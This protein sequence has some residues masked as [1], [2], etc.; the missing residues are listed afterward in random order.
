MDVCERVAATIREYGLLRRGQKVVAAV[1]GGADS[2]CLLDC[3]HRLGFP[4]VVAHLNHRLREGSEAD[5]EYTLRIAQQYGLPV[6][7]ASEDVR[8]LARG[9]SLEEAARVARYRFLARVARE[10][11]AR[12]VAT[13]HTSD[14]QAETVLLHLLRGAGPLGL[15]GMLPSTDLSTWIG[16]AAGP[17]LALIRPL[18][19]I[20]HE[21]TLA[22]CAH[23]G[24]EPR[25][26]PTNTDPAFL[27]NRIRLELLPALETYNP[28]IRR[29]LERTARLMRD[30]AE[31][32][33]RMA[34][35]A[36]PEFARAAGEAALA[37]S[38]PGLRR[39]PPALRG[40]LVRRALSAVR[41]EA[42]DFGLEDVERVLEVL[43]PGSGLRRA[44]IGNG[45]EV[46]RFGDEAYLYQEGTSPSF[47]EYPQLPTP[48]ERRLGPSAMVRLAQKWRLVTKTVR[49]SPQARR[50]LMRNADPHLA[51]FDPAALPG[52][53]SL[54]PPRPGDRLR[55]LGMQGSVKVAD[56]LIDRHIPRPARSQWPILVSGETP[57]WAVGLRMGTEARLTSAS[58]RAL[59]VQLEPPANV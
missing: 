28:A 29:V 44:S 40:E 50:G 24:L 16:M 30:Q 9:R 7:V 51:A 25:L 17:R 47:P 54:R 45:L 57:I 46:E 12:A 36:W 37:L 56:L 38:L 18:L 33:G 8:A 2:L 20:S 43:S 39:Q 10:H 4:V 58:K 49:L 21:Q 15:R 52:P 11:R 35:E 19:D 1:S 34:D 42:R 41:P 27:R 6:V 23:R 59:L 26:D 3:L 14:D 53:L 22:H 48:A 55:P 13:G 31:L 5:A 32:V